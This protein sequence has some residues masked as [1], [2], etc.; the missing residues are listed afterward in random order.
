M[1]KYYRFN[2]TL[3]FS[4][5]ALAWVV[6]ASTAQAGDDSL[7]S[8]AEI[9][10]DLIERA[11]PWVRKIPRDTYLFHYR[12]RE[13]SEKGYV[14]PQDQRLADHFS[15]YIRGTIDDPNAKLR[16]LGFH[17][18][19][20]DGLYAALDPMISANY[21]APR[22]MWGGNDRH[23]WVLY[24]FTLRAGSRYWN[25]VSS[26]QVIFPKKLRKSLIAQYGCHAD[27]LNKLLILNTE[28]AIPCRP[29]VRT[30]ISELGVD[31]ILY[32]W[33]SHPNYRE[34]ICP[35]SPDAAFLLTNRTP[36]K[37]E[38]VLIMNKDLPTE[39]D[40]ASL[41]RLMIQRLFYFAEDTNSWRWPSLN[42]KKSEKKQ[43]LAEL[44]VWARE[45]L[46]R[47]DAPQPPTTK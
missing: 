6:S 7:M 38:E 35:K 45:H 39:P 47:C 2:G 20:G 31:A 19:F 15:A 13:E 44:K 17:D 46:F 24:R 21:G 27:T 37:K 40:A 16:V 12:P 8:K 9:E 10:K 32:Q 34:K 23:P 30:I 41:D 4:L 5:A 22:G 18:W 26:W 36:F 1:L 11:S 3:K 14:V 29:L 43:A 28:K 25:I 42:P 33:K